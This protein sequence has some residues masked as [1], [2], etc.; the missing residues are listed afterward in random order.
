MSTEQRKELYRN[1][2][3]LGY[4]DRETANIVSEV[5]KVVGVKK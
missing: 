5:L 3:S 4:D 2:K 1:L